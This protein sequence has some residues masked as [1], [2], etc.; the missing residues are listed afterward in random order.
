MRILLG[1]FFSLNVPYKFIVIR[2]SLAKIVKT[3]SSPLL[4]DTSKLQLFTQQQ[5]RKP[6]I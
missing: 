3:L 6:R 4:T 1:L 5:L 2:R